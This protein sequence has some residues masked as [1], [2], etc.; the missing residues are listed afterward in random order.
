MLSQLI[1]LVCATAPLFNETPQI[2]SC[3]STLEG[4]NF[5]NIPS[6][7]WL[8]RANKKGVDIYSY[9]YLELAGNPIGGKSQGVGNAGSL[10]FA[11]RLDLDKLAAIN[12]LSFFTSVIFRSGE[13]LSAKHIDNQFSV[14]QLYGGE[15][16]RLNELYLEE[17]LLDGD[18]NIKAGRLTGG[19]DFLASPFY[20]EFVNNAF[21]GNPISIFFNTPFLAYPFS[22]WGAYLDFKPHP[23]LL[24]KFAVYNDNVNVVRN[25]YHGVYFPFKSTKG[26]MWISEWVYLLNQR[27]GSRGYPGNYKVGAYYITGTVPKFEGGS[28]KGNDGFY[29]L[30]DQL[31]YR[32]GG[33][34]TTQGLSAFSAFLFAPKNR[35][36][37]PFF[38]TSGLI[39]KGIVPSR[40][41][42]YLSF[43]VGY[44]AYSED[45]R[46]VQ[47]RAQETGMTGIFGDRPQNFETVLEL[48]YWYRFNKYLAL[49]PDVQ[50]IINPKGFGTIQNAFVVALQISIDLIGSPKRP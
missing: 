18:C 16:I 31:L 15:T 42:D 24:L 47:R 1:P 14:T 36:E 49:T 3:C 29:L 13:S 23:D 25:K 35:N 32:E 7:D 39:Y 45:L 26:V 6:G 33:V 12:G 30:F 50:Y 8:E 11:M 22:T 48:N 5:E 19:N 28:H 43:G 46:R 9:Y 34:G 38:L 21:C 37:F 44:G 17:T 41:D 40:K 20:C 4:L 2:A 27:K 10:G